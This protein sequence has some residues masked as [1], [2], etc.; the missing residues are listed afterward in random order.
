MPAEANGD[1]RDYELPSSLITPDAD[2]ARLW[3]VI[4]Q[5]GKK[6]FTNTLSHIRTGRKE[7]DQRIKVGDSREAASFGAEASSAIN[8]EC[9]AV[10]HIQ[11]VEQSHRDALLKT[12]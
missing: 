5:I 4:L 8:W 2:V 9:R 10:V 11:E 12:K 3:Y 6:C 7:T 1:R